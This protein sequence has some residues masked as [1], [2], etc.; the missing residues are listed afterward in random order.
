[1]SHESY[2]T[3]AF[4]EYKI[5]VPP[6]LSVLENGMDDLYRYPR[7]YVPCDLAGNT[8][9]Q[10]PEAQAHYLRHVLRLENSDMIR[11]FNGRD[12]E[13]TARL[14][15]KGKHDASVSPEKFVKS[16]PVRTRRIHLFFPPLKKDRLDILIEKAVELDAT[17][18]HP[19]IT[20]RTEVRDIKTDRLEKQIIEAAEQCERLD[21]P[22]LHPIER[23]DKKLVT[24]TKMPIFLGMERSDAKPLCD[25]LVPAGDVAALI[26]PAG[27]WTENE[28][29]LLQH[30]KTITAVT[31][32]PNILRSE[33]AAI[34]MLAHL[35]A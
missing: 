7:L 6:T 23:L 17:D 8:Q 15:L 5:P 28:R 12:G 1:M 33:T 11:L 19:V 22:T 2:L 35:Q 14:D 9:F 27:G 29:D 10:L 26:G 25:E 34:V 32:G 13:W 3:T 16:Q 21:I 24:W 30:G 31:L 4:E 18:L 20:E